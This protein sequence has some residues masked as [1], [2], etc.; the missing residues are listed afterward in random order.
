MFTSQELI[1][2]SSALMLL[3]PAEITILSF[4]QDDFKST[5]AEEEIQIHRG[6]AAQFENGLHFWV[7]SIQN[8]DW[9]NRSE[10]LFPYLQ[11]GKCLMISEAYFNQLAWK[12]TL[13]LKSSPSLPLHSECNF[14]GALCMYDDWN[15]V[16]IVAG[17]D[18]EYIAFYW[19][20]SA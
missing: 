14:I 9:H 6:D 4:T 15:D 20:T 8:Q 3:P 17:Y 1:E 13:N 5:D 19:S 12:F 7:K 10:Y 2:N 16:A 18:N 11:E